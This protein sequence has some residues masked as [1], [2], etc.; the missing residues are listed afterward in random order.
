MVFTFHHEANR[1]DYDA[2]IGNDIH[3]RIYKNN[4]LNFA[5]I[6]PYDRI[7]GGK[8]Y[9]LLKEATGEIDVV[10]WAVPANEDHIIDIPTPSQD[11]SITGELLTVQPITRAIAY[12]SVGRLYL[13]T[14]T[15]EE[16]DLASETKVP[17]LMNNCVAQFSATIHNVPEYYEPGQTETVWLEIAGTK[18]QMDIHFTPK[19]DD[20]VIMA[21]FTEKDDNGI[22]NTNKH[23]LLPSA[24]DQF[25]E[26]KVYRGDEYQGMIYT[27]IQ[28][29]P[30]DI[31]HLDIYRNTITIT[32][33]D[34]RVFEIPSLSI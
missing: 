24:D 1:E 18:S 31:I 21:E 22:L 25:L 32:V 34:W 6:I 11:E 5:G 10:A 9:R 23:S 29:R 17:V 19:G 27:D 20:A 16:N 4:Y 14:S 28:S 12:N 2:A 15:Y 3:L 30:G 26:V 13:G 7:E 8:E 33:N